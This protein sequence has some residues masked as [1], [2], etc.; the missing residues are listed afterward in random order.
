MAS[1]PRHSAASKV[2]PARHKDAVQ[3]ILD[4]GADSFVVSFVLPW[5]SSA[6][7]PNTYAHH[8][9]KARQKKAYRAEIGAEVL[10]QMLLMPTPVRIP[11]GDLALHLFFVRPTYRHCD[12]D[13]LIARMK[14][15]IDGMCDALR[16]DDRRFKSLSGKLAAWTEQPACV[17]VDITQLEEKKN[18]NEGV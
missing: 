13:N 7:S 12:L 15:G 17:I 1:R 14:A 6:L 2:H 3:R 10:E 18:G 11:D 8:H 16:I 5:P 9:Y 4:R